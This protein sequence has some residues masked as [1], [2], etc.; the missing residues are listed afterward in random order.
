MSTTVQ[1]FVLHVTTAEEVWELML[2]SPAFLQSHHS[3]PAIESLGRAPLLCVPRSFPAPGRCLAGGSS[4]KCIFRTPT[5]RR[6]NDSLAILVFSWQLMAALSTYLLIYFL[7][8]YCTYLLCG[9][10][11]S[12]SSVFTCERGSHAALEAWTPRWQLQGHENLFRRN[13]DR[14]WLYRPLS[15]SLII[16]YR[17]K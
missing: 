12:N 1:L 10:N 14:Q 2:L 11:S 17:R 8:I 16:W 5:I 13:F 6:R 4:S 9:V 7:L 15:D 3:S